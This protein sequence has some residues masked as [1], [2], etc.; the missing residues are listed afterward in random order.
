MRN[1]L[2]LLLVFLLITVACN[3]PIQAVQ[4][5]SPDAP[6]IRPTDTVTPI[7]FVVIR[8][9]KTP[10]PT[11][12]IHPSVTLSPT[13][14]SA[15]PTHVPADIPFNIDCSALPE[16]RK[17]DCDTYITDTRDI[18]Y[19]VLQDITGTTLASCYQ[20]LT[21]IILPEAPGDGAGGLCYGDTIK[22]DQKY[23]IDLDRRY[24]VHEIIHSFN[25][26]NKALDSHVLHGMVT[27]AVYDRIGVTDT[28]YYIEETDQ[29]ITTNLDMLIEQSKTATG[30]E[31]VDICRG[32][33]QRKMTR[34]YFDLGPEAV[35]PLYQATIKPVKNINPPSDL[36]FTMW[37]NQSPQVQALLETLQNQ[38]NY[39]L[40]VPQCGY[41]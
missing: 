1:K 19:P 2:L 7:P 28:R 8:L 9:S 4:T 29:N 30:P 31:L 34:A 17:A 36:L 32:I 6:L 23:S 38:Y 26:C 12:T 11:P 13:V 27:D 20:S 41:W 33:L 16:N 39:T 10:S 15:T 24:D 5:P 18:V 40:N 3:L 35:Q 37:N 14:A 25:L 21:Y 22:F